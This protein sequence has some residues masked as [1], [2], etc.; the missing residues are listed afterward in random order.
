[1]KMHYCYDVHNRWF[2]C[3]IR[4][5][6]ELLKTFLAVRDHLNF[7][8]AAEVRL[9]TQPGVSKQIRQLEQ[10]VGVPL[11]ERLGKA[12]HLTDAGRTLAPLA[13]E[14]LGQMTR[15]AEAVGG[16]RG[17]E[18][19]CIRIGASTTPG[20]Y[21]LPEAL[22]RFSRKFPGVELQFTVEN[23]LA[24][25]RRIIRNDLDLG[26]VGGHLSNA[27]LKMDHVMN[28]EVI[29]FCAPT[30]PLARLRRITPTALAK[31]I[32]VIRERGS[33]TR[34]LFEERLSAV[35]IKMTQRIELSSPE[36]IKALVAAGVGVSFLS[37][38]ALRSEFEQ[39]RLKPLRMPALRLTRPIYAI[40][41]IDKHLSPTMQAF[42]KLMGDRIGPPEPT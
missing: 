39:G 6:A 8:R 12:I 13:E 36:G 24:I 25:E 35:G 19:G 10:Q 11:F 5:N 9:L 15:V 37:T 28:D 40:R 34:Q 30:Y 21:L 2:G 20:H 26:F 27:I 1:M 7:T 23:S 42:L 22:G 38:L 3:L 33:A 4:M 32:W 14:L 17:A 29:C 18:R 41:H 16:Y 31:Q